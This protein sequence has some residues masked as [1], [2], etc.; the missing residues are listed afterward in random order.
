MTF[1]PLNILTKPA[2]EF[3]HQLIGASDIVRQLSLLKSEHVMRP[4][5]GE[6]CRR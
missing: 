4:L 1:T 3:V 6:S 5:N 2:D